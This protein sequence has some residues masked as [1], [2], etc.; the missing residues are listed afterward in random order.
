MNAFSSHNT[1]CNLPILIV[2]RFFCFIWKQTNKNTKTHM[3]SS[4][5]LFYKSANM[6][7]KAKRSNTMDKLNKKAI[8]LVE[9]NKGYS[10][11]KSMESL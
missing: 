7:R 1:K 4:F 10:D 3:L 11:N 9:L 5:T 8:S 6:Q 2:L